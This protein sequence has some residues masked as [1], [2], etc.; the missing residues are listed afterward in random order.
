MAPATVNS[1]TAINQINSVDQTLKTGNFSHQ[2][3]LHNMEHRIAAAMAVNIKHIKRQFMNM[4][5]QQPILTVQV[6][7]QITIQ[8]H[9]NHQPTQTHTQLQQLP[10][11]AI[12]PI[13]RIRPLK[14]IQPLL[15]KHTNHHTQMH[16]THPHVSLS[17]FFVFCKAVKSILFCERHKRTFRELH[18]RHE[19][20]FQFFRK[21]N[22]RF[23][24]NSTILSKKIEFSIKILFSKKN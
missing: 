9:S 1:A 3:Q 4:L 19:L 21:T 10:P 5:R 18:E 6:Q 24:S 8:P 17:Q 23:Q 20:K 16:R 12:Q 13:Q 14:L 11:Q 15:H 2:L 7:I 22:A